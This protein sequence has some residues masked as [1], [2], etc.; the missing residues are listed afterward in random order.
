MLINPAGPDRISINAYQKALRRIVKRSGTKSHDHFSMASDFTDSG[1]I[2]SKD[3][4]FAYAALGLTWVSPRELDGSGFGTG[5][6]P[7]KPF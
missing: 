7:V 3:T 6:N 1:L 4:K 2:V 5:L